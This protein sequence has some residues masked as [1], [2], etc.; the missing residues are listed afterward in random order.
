MEIPTSIHFVIR[1]C[2]PALYEH[3]FFDAAWRAANNAELCSRIHGQA[4]D[5]IAAFIRHGILEM[6]PECG[7]QLVDHMLACMKES[8]FD[9]RKQA[10]LSCL[11]LIFFT[12]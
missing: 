3:G 8:A 1:I 9:L 10:S 5:L 6:R 4:F 11:V 12:I 2:I 7:A